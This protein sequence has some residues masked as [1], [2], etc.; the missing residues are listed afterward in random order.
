MLRLQRSLRLKNLESTLKVGMPVKFD[1][2]YNGENRFYIVTNIRKIHNM[3]WLS[4][5][6]IDGYLH[7]KHII[8]YKKGCE[9]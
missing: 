9:K 2:T 8:D 7:F 6:G 5:D 3:M 1:F 4:V